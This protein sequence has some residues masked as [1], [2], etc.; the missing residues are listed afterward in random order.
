VFS[1]DSNATLD[2]LNFGF[3]ADAKANVSLP[4][5]LKRGQC[6]IITEDTKT[7]WQLWTTIKAHVP[8]D[9]L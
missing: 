4:I 2:L 5:M 9:P 8:L 3:Y 6:I 1:L 7:E